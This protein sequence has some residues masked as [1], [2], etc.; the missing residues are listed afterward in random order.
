LSKF[1]IETGTTGKKYFCASL[2]AIGLYSLLS[3]AGVCSGNMIRALL[4]V[5]AKEAAALRV[6]IALSSSSQSTKNELDA[7]A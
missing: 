4:N 7:F 2:N 3:F 1:E 6:F 5:F